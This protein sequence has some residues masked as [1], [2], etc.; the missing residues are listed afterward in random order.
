MY[1]ELLKHSK[2]TNNPIF[3]GAK[4]LNRYVT[5]ENTQLASE[6]ITRYSADVPR[7]PTLTQALLQALGMEQSA[8][9]VEV[10]V[11]MQLTL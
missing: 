5:K 9:P 3:K 6:H 4:E 8:K 11:L 7:A 10:F 2:K 1:K